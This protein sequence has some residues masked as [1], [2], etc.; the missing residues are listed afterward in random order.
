MFFWLHPSVQILAFIIAGYAFYLA[1]A[2]IR[3]LH[4]DIKCQF[5]WQTHVRA[6]RWAI[7]LWLVGTLL[8]FAGAFME[9]GAVFVTGTHAFIGLLFVPLAIFGAQTGQ[10]C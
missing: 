5:C 1:W 9:W 7:A 6:G 8:G 10:C 2:R 4:F 3:F